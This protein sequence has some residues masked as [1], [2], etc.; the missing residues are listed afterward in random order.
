MMISPRAARGGY[1]WLDTLTH[2][3]THLVLSQATLDRAPLW[4]QEGVAKRQE[5]RWRERG[6]FDAQPS[7]DAVALDGMKRGLALPLTELGPSIAML[8]TAEQAAIAFAEVSSFINYWIDKNGKQALPKLL[9][10][11]R[12]APPSDDV[13]KAIETVSG[14]GLA[15]WDKRWRAHLGSRTAELSQELNGGSPII[16]GAKFARRRRLGQLLLERR[17]HSAAHHQLSLAHQIIGRETSVRCMLA[18]AHAGLGELL[19]ASS[20]V[21]EPDDIDHASGRWWSLHHGYLGLDA[22]PQARWRALAHDPLNPAVACHELE[23]GEYPS[24]P[25]HRALCLAA[26][27]V[28]QP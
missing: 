1:P 22:F 19:E 12:D 7:A 27:R 23:E 2:E 9:T 10:A 28:P 11:I 20:L 15:E 18:D 3:L 16:D 5:T 26:W 25:I 21:S 13:S 4:L 24:D 17:H 14:H 6:P 8:P